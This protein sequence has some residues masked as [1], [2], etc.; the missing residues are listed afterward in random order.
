[1]KDQLKEKEQHI[2]QLLKERDLE[3]AEVAKAASQTDEAE[4]ILAQVRQEFEAYRQQQGET[5]SIK[6]LLEEERKRNEDLQFRLEESEILRSEGD[7]GCTEVEENLKTLRA[8]IIDLEE[9]NLVLNSEKEETEKKL[10]KFEK[11]DV[12]TLDLAKENKDLQDNLTIISKELAQEQKRCE[13]FETEANKY[14]EIEE[15]LMEK[16][17]E[18]AMLQKNFEESKASLEREKN[19]NRDFLSSQ[20]TEI[21]S[22]SEKLFE[23]EKKCREKDAELLELSH[24]KEKIEQMGEELQSKLSKI[25]TELTDMKKNYQEMSVSHDKAKTGVEDSDRELAK[26]TEELKELRCKVANDADERIEDQ[27]Q[28]EE[29]KKIISSKERQ[30]KDLKSHIESNGTNAEKELEQKNEELSVLQARED[31]HIKELSLLKSQIVSKDESFNELKGSLIVHEK[32]IKTL[33]ELKAGLEKEISSL[34]ESQNVSSLE[35]SRLQ[36]SSRKNEGVLNEFKN[37]LKCEKDRNEEL[38][39]KIEKLELNHKAEIEER[40]YSFEDQLAET[41]KTIKNLEKDLEIS[42]KALNARQAQFEEECNDTSKEHNF[43]IG[44]LQKTIES[45]ITKIEELESKILTIREESINKDSKSDGFIQT[46]AKLEQQIVNVT[47]EYEKQLEELR[48]VIDE[49]QKNIDKISKSN[50]Q[51]EDELKQFDKSKLTVSELTIKISDLEGRENELKTDILERD[52][53]ID[54]L[55]SS[56]GSSNELLDH[57]RTESNK[58]TQEIASLKEER[59]RLTQNSQKLDVEMENLKEKNHKEMEKVKNKLENDIAILTEKYQKQREESEELGNVK[60]DLTQRLQ[61]EADSSVK[62]INE[63]K[64]DKESLLMSHENE[65]TSINKEMEGLRNII[66]EREEKIDKVMK[67]KSDLESQLAKVKGEFDEEM[68]EMVDVVNDL[69]VKEEELSSLEREMKSKNN[70]I[71]ELCK[72]MLQQEQSHKDSIRRKDKILEDEVK[73][74]ENKLEESQKQ[75]QYLKDQLGNTKVEC[76]LQIQKLKMEFEVEIDKLN[77]TSSIK[78]G[79]IDRLKD[80]VSS[81]DSE[82]EFLKEELKNKIE[83][84]EDI[85][86]DLDIKEASFNNES[87]EVEE[88]HKEEIEELIKK[89][90]TL[91][92]TIGTLKES[93]VEKN[94][95]FDKKMDD[96]VRLKK[97]EICDLKDRVS[98]REVQVMDLQ[99]TLKEF[100]ERV[101]QLETTHSG[102]TKLASSKLEKINGENEL[103]RRSKYELETSVKNI[104]MEKDHILRLTDDLNVRLVE[105]EVQVKEMRSQYEELQMEYQ[106]QSLVLKE[107]TDRASLDHG[108]LEDLQKLLD[109]ERARVDELQ[110]SLNENEQQK[111]QLE[112]NLKAS[113]RKCNDFDKLVTFNENVTTEAAEL[114]KKN[115]FLFE[116]IS[117][118]RLKYESQIELLQEDIDSRKKDFSIKEFEVIQLKKENTDL[119]SYKRQVLTL[120]SEKRELETQLV[121]AVSE[122]RMGVNKLSSPPPTE[123][124]DVAVDDGLNMQIDFLNSVIVDM[125]K[126]ND[127]LSAQLEIYETAG[128]LGKSSLSLNL[129]CALIFNFCLD[130]TSEFIFNGV[131]S[132]AVPPRMFC[133][134]CDQFDL[135]ETEDCPTQVKTR[136]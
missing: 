104:T 103:L 128:I 85:A 73:T 97:S 17:E 55:K 41:K 5:P 121:T 94:A 92:L 26:L 62:T 48:T 120:E 4:A 34:K 88:A 74:M 95:D 119:T 90:E 108:S 39:K 118:E 84:L 29:L 82:I 96:L 87:K 123:S 50:R 106:K 24:E 11:L 15:Q 18:M 8:K 20:K 112:E 12:R 42:R 86:S 52:K 81:K 10:D 19:G 70:K 13:K 110:L 33:T 2:E 63:M 36:D 7:K 64:A 16:K 136:S 54:E 66:L 98:E 1:M 69:K 78:D 40:E 105:Y 80:D 57:L 14:F 134:I 77:G 43:E 32:N 51:L 45:N 89:N 114:K 91:T 27:R 49:E 102:E 129:S 67:Q 107:K 46:I 31:D 127:K 117:K 75:H 99:A 83:E 125:Q 21:N 93:I 59:A 25:S 122:S 124:T 9:K 130:E 22:Q 100:E 133:D 79:L 28:I 72:Q 71:D 53:Q 115:Q 76:D 38:N 23:A 47:A 44:K 30:N 131:S 35:V 111:E 60:K 113:E 61:K 56:S 3:R 101:H 132:R 6:E 58:M 116:E 109:S 126:K 65:V 68:S 37:N 135:H